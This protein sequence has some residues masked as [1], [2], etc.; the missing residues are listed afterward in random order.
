MEKSYSIAFVTYAIHCGGMETFLIRLARYLK[1]EGFEVVIVTT[2]SPGEWFGLVKKMGINI[3][4]IEGI[5]RYARIFHF[6]KVYREL[7]KGDYDVIFLNH[8]RFAQAIIRMLPDKLPI[9]PILHND[10]KWIYKI[11]CSSSDAWNMLIAVSPK[12]LENARSVVKNRPIKLISYGVE[13]P[14]NALQI[15]KS[16]ID[17]PFNLVYIGHLVNAQKGILLLPYIFRLLINNGV[18]FNASI[19]GDGPDKIKLYNLLKRLNLINK[20]SLIESLPNNRVYQILSNAHILLLPSYYEG[21]G[22]VLL[23]AQ[24]NRCVPICSKLTGI[25]DFAVVNGVTGM[26]VDIGDIEGFANAITELYLNRIKWRKMAESGY[27][28]VREKFSADAMGR[29]YKQIILDLVNGKYPLPKSRK[30]LFPNLKLI[31]WKD[32]VPTSI[33]KIVSKLKPQK[34][35]TFSFLS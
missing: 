9:V 27:N 33:R 5:D 7:K 17:K 28:Y 10:H 32:F 15:I 8:A 34:S 22:I 24:A 14:D 1:K 30:R 25:T 18:E 6:F 2:E 20:V 21:L 16:K 35:S 3:K 11:G 26:L 31:S 13:I 29:K 23:E 12:L 4:H 19:V